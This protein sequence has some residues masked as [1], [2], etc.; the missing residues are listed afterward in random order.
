[1]RAAV[2]GAV[3]TV[4]VLD[5][6][7]I[8]AQ[9]VEHAAVEMRTNQLAASVWVAGGNAMAPVAAQAEEAP[10]ASIQYIAA[11]DRQASQLDA[12]VTVAVNSANGCVE[13]ARARNQYTED[14]ISFLWR[15]GTRRELVDAGMI[16]EWYPPPKENWFGEDGYDDFSD[17]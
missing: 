14:E 10:S 1:M 13:T 2:A 16:S 4:S 8:D 3:A 7:R 11:A 17:C 9:I 6:P 12:S 15:H 5:T